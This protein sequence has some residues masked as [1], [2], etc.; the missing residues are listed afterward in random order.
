VAAQAYCAVAL[1]DGRVRLA[2]PEAHALGTGQAAR[3]AAMVLRQASGQSAAISEAAEREAAEIRRQAS[4]QSAAIRKAAELEAAELRAVIEMSAGL[5]GVV[6]SGLEDLISPA[7]PVTRRESQFITQP[8]AK[9]RTRPGA[10]TK[11][12]QGR[13]M[14]QAAVI[15][16]ALV[17]AGVASGTT[18]IAVHGLPFFFFRNAG[19]GAGNAQ[20]L[21]EN[22]GPGQPDTPRAHRP[23]P[24]ARPSGQP[25]PKKAPDGQSGFPPAPVRAS[26]RR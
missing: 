3:E 26:V 19:A 4:A 17:L 23:S 25:S 10:G 6:V 5:G 20:N 21:D 9:P 8:A 15:T 2:W 22:Q 13:A 11:G 16:V 1:G 18:E 24:A 7:Q 14:R 12:R